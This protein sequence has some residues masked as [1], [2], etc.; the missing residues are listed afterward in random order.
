DRANRVRATG[1]L[2]SMGS[3][4]Y[5]QAPL[6]ASGPLFV[7]QGHKRVDSGGTAGRNVASEQS[8]GG[9]PKRDS[10][11]GERITGLDAEQNRR[12]QTGNAKRQSHSDSYTDAGELEA[13][14]RDQAEDVRLTSAKSHADANFV[15]TLTYG[16]GHHAIDAYSGEQY[17]YACEDSE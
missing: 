1:C 17:G 12:D 11:V 9:E 3:S 13:E 4:G 10:N 15:R 16:I 7:T 2:Q 6:G 5:L 8:N 14:P